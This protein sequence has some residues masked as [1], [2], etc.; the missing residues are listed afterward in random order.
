MQKLI[1]IASTSSV[2]QWKFK[3]WRILKGLWFD[4]IHISYEKC[5]Y[6]VMH[7]DGIGNMLVLAHYIKFHFLNQ[8]V[9]TYFPNSNNNWKKLCFNIFLFQIYLLI[10]QPPHGYH[11]MPMICERIISAIRDILSFIFI[12]FFCFFF[13]LF[14]Y[15][16]W[17]FRNKLLLWLF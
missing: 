1:Y 2:S 15:Y 16:V 8:L 11:G 13:F 5:S 3:Y 12:F 17:L 7:N 14:N 4:T 6:L 10:P 9:L